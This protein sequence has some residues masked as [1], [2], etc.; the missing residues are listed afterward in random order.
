VQ[1]KGT[2]TA[3]LVLVAM[4]LAN[5]MILVDQ[6]AVPLT[7]PAIMQDFGVQ[8][9][10]VQWVLNGSLLPLAGL[11]VLSDLLGRRRIFLLA[12]GL[13]PRRRRRAGVRRC[14]DRRAG[15]GAIGIALLYAVFH[16]TYIGQLH[17]RVN[18]GPSRRPHQFRVR[19]AAQRH[20]GG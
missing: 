4:T 10:A 8:S 15:G 18:Q 11:L 16:A 12:A 19:H 1:A 14:R 13:D 5:S 7:L 3:R 6:T 9:Q 2:A 17:Q 20:R